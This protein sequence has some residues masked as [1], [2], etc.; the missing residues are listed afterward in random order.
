MN[1]VIALT[2]EDK[3]QLKHIY[4]KRLFYFL[5]IFGILMVAALLKGS[6]PLREKRDIHGHFRWDEAHLTQNEMT[7]LSLLFI[8]LPV[9]IFSG[10][11][12]I[13]RIDSFR[14]D[15]R[16]GVKEAI[17]YTI[18]RKTCME[19]TGQYF[20]SFDDADYM[21]HEVDWETYCKAEIG[22]T[23]EIYRAPFS[24]YSFNMNNEYTVI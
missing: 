5:F 11:L 8:V 20:L 2:E 12:Y 3:A 4:R 10:I 9:L 13:K 7:L 1:H 24:K 19:E 16:N 22:G 21:H 18:I 23:I 14:K 17:C 15:I 6:A